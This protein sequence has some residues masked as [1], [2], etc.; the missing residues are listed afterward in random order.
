MSRVLRLRNP[1]LGDEG[2]EPLCWNGGVDGV[3][4]VQ[5]QEMGSELLEMGQVNEHSPGL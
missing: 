5:P 4:L 3:G 1:G 2:T